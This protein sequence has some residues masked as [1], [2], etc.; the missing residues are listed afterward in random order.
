MKFTIDDKTLGRILIGVAVVAVI[1]IIIFFRHRSK[2]EWPI[3]SA[4][5]SG[6][7]ETTLT[8]ALNSAQDA[9]NVR[10]ISINTMPNGA[11]KDTQKM[12]AERTLSDAIDAAVSSY[13]SNKCT[14]VVNGTKP[15]DTTGGDAYDA[16]QTTDLPFIGGAYYTVM[17]DATGQVSTETLAARKADITGATRKYIAT[18]CPKFYKT[19]GAPDP[20]QTYKNWVSYA[21]QAAY[22]SAAVPTNGGSKVGFAKD[23]ITPANI[24]TWADYAAV[25]TT[26]SSSVTVAAG[27]TTI[28]PI[29]LDSVTDFTAQTTVQF[30]P[31]TAVN[32]VTS[33]LAPITATIA[34]V[35][36]AAKTVTLTVTAVPTSGY[37]IPAKTVFAKALK[38]G[39]SS[40]PNNK[41]KALTANTPNWKLARDAGPGTL[42]QPSW[43]P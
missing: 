41:W 2:F 36:T 22:D 4:D 3:A 33:P 40:T 42:P 7:D 20:S 1:L 14:A 32:G 39:T 6:T 29:T 38:P 35:D 30:T 8:N 15:A 23:R 18:A 28:G 34:A 26:S 37:I 31:Q 24:S 19:V 17:K 21:T 27:A 9:Y 13:V 10:M 12:T 5:R 16:Y 43:A 25:T 11:S